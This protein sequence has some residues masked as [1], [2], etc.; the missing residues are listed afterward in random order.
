MT[1]ETYYPYRVTAR[2]KSLYASYDGDLTVH[3]RNDI[4]AEERARRELA[5]EYKTDQIVIY[6]IER[7]RQ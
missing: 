1:D 5:R 2:V 6:L 4:E 7:V 3:A